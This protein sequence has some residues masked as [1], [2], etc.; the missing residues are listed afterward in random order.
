MN[1]LR[2]SLNSE[3][4]L[5]NFLYL[6]KK[7]TQV[8]SPLWVPWSTYVDIDEGIHKRK[9]K[10]AGKWKKNT[11]VFFLYKYKVITLINIGNFDAFLWNLNVSA[12]R[13]FWRCGTS[14]RF[15]KFAYTLLYV[16]V[17]YISS[18]AVNCRKL[19]ISWWYIL[20]RVYML[21]LFLIRT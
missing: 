7:K 4:M 2:S 9:V 19:K 1:D 3:E 6:C 11:W 12:N 21:Q 17:S 5:Q 14:E 8:V 20:Y 13:F 16:F 18:T 10:V 15:Q